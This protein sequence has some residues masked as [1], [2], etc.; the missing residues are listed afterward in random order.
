MP[1]R[2]LALVL[3]M[4]GTV[5]AQS[6]TTVE[7]YGPVPAIQVYG[8]LGTNITS[9]NAWEYAAA[10]A[11][12][13]T[14]GRFDCPWNTVELQTLP[15]NT[16]GGYTWP[17]NCAA[18][19]SNGATYGVQPI[20]DALYGAP[21]GSIL[22]GTTSADSPSGTTVVHISVSSGSFSSVVNGQTLLNPAGG[23]HYGAKASYGGIL[24]IANNGS[25][26][27]TLA[28]ALTS[29]MPSGTAITLNLLLYPPFTPGAGA[30]PWITPSVVAYGGYAA[31][32]AGKISS[33]GMTGRVSLWNEPPWS[34]DPWDWAGNFYDSPPAYSWNPG[35]QNTGVE[36]GLYVASLTP[37]SGVSYENGAPNKSGSN[38]LM[39]GGLGFAYLQNLA[40]AQKAFGGEGFHP[41]GNN[42]E[43]A[44]WLQGCL[45]TQSVPGG[46]TS[47][48]TPTGGVS[49]SNFKTAFAYGQ[50]PLNFGGLGFDITE[51]G[52]DLANGATQTQLARFELRQFLGYQGL[53]VTPV[54]FYRLFGDTNFQWCS[55][56]SGP[57]CYPVYYDFQNAM[58]D[59]GGIAA[60]PVAPYS[61]CM[62]PRV[63][64]YSGY[65][66]LA[67][68][69]Y[70]GSVAGNKA[71][72]LLF[73]TWQ[74]SYSATNWVTL[75]SPASV[76]V[77]LVVPTGLT[78][79]SVKDL[80]TSNSVGYSFS[81]GTLTYGVVDDPVEVLLSPVTATTAATLVCT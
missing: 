5:M 7:T 31:Y 81:S 6:V 40:T 20:I 73:Y 19:L 9:T 33:A 55:A 61:P 70:V 38:S 27:V 32:V 77:S 12:H 51:T 26:T 1:L 34:G 35:N 8:G 18:G 64:S 14:W 11:A 16:S 29:D 28:S 80:I 2:R 13:I 17:S 47:T 69:A 68:V 54:V 62:M 44:M 48:C 60:S 4:S 49:G 57:T 74:R 66:P 22:T 65:F 39:W 24:V 76:N 58:N 30:T 25:S 71:N 67:T 21:Y 45:R 42:P 59:I 75:A 72:S 63:S 43:D 50:Y 52:I 56:S 23:N 10:Q 3:W 36:L 53:G 46:N 37:P 79:T 78:V 15:A 41:Y